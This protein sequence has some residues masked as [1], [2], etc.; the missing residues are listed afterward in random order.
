MGIRPAI[1]ED[2][3]EY[4]KIIVPPPGPKARD[5]IARDARTVSQNLTKDMPLVV[6]TAA[7]MVV[8]DVDGNR[9]LDFA[10][11]IS[12]VSTGHCHPEV[13]KAIRKQAESLIHIC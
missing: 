5:V 1:V 4:P 7:G 11:G 13:T 3:D 6:A 8:E 10:A 12:T 2:V 9:F